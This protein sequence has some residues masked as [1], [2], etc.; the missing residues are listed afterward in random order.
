MC[1]H[2]VDGNAKEIKCI[3]QLKTL[4]AA[5]ELHAR[6]RYVFLC[7]FECSMENRFQVSGTCIECQCVRCHREIPTFFFS[8]VP[9]CCRN[10]FACC[11]RATWKFLVSDSRFWYRVRVSLN[12]KHFLHIFPC[13][14]LKAHLDLFFGKIVMPSFLSSV[15]GKRKFCSSNDDSVW[16]EYT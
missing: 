14:E 12:G 13:V 11:R 15:S 4:L 3:L 9:C 6:V 16:L 5:P 8:H 10:G 2:V 1:R 7:E